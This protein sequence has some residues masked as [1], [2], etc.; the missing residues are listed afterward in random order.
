LRSGAFIGNKV[1]YHLSTALQSAAAT[2]CAGKQFNRRAVLPVELTYFSFPR[3][4]VSILLPLA[5]VEV[6]STI[7]RDAVDP[8]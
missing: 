5:L 7:K 1:L 4:S 3:F 6:F 8:P 2:V